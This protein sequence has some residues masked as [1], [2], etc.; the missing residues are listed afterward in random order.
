MTFSKDEI[1]YHIIPQTDWEKVRQQDEYRP[2]SL[3]EVGFIHFS[4]RTQV[5]GTLARFYAGQTGL[6]LLCVTV[7]RLKNEIRYEPAEGQEFPHLYG[8]LNLDAV[9]EVIKIEPGARD[10]LSGHAV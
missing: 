2:A 7:T 8:A 4:T 1:I 9:V 3:A 5:A 6:L 10:P